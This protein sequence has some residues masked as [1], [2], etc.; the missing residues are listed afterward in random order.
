MDEEKF[1]KLA[2]SSPDFIKKLVNCISPKE[3]SKFLISFG[4]ETTFSE[5]NK[6]FCAVR[7]FEVIDYED[8]KKSEKEKIESASGGV[9]TL[10]LDT[11][12]DLIRGIN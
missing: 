12:A 3:V 9:S 7:N 1:I 2:Q 8:A 6:I 11:L 4:I 5:S 10:V